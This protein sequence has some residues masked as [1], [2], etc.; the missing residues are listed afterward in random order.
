MRFDCAGSM[1]DNAPVDWQCTLKEKDIKP[2]VGL[3]LFATTPHVSGISCLA[4]RPVRRQKPDGLDSAK[5]HAQFFYALVQ[6]IW[7]VI[8]S[9]QS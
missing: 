7:N 2:Y 8:G 6:H 9:E 4:R 3:K 5:E 1:W